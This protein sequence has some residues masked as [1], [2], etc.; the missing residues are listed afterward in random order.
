MS[1]ENV[2]RIKP[3]ISVLLM[4]MTLFSVVFLQMEERRL[5]Y[6]LLKLN[7]QARQIA[8][9]KKNYEIQL[10]QITRPQFVEKMAASRFTLR[11]AQSDQIILLPNIIVSAD[12]QELFE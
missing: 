7:K 9:N 11:K 1:S 10:A 3:L 12:N 8:E 4:I 2:N 6:S 5:G